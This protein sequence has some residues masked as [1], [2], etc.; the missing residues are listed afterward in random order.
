MILT[1]Q[2]HKKSII[3]FVGMCINFFFLPPAVQPSHSHLKPL[4]QKKTS[5]VSSLIYLQL[6]PDKHNFSL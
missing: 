3:E 6:L 1:V 2:Y 5:A 4:A